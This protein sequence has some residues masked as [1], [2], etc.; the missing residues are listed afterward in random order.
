MFWYNS[1]W[2][3]VG[4]LIRK[5]KKKKD[6]L[7]LPFKIRAVGGIISNKRKKRKGKKN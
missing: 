5:A 2:I 3:W 4:L 7:H 1:V 6:Q